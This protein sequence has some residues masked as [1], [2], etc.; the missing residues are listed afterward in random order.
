MKKS[1]LITGSLFVTWMLIIAF[2]I[3][4]CKKDDNPIK[5]P[6]GTIPDTTTTALA[7][8]NSAYDDYNLSLYQLYDSYGLIFSSNRGSSGGQFDLEQGAVSFIWDQT[9]GTFGFGS[10]ET[11]DIF[12]SALT[13]QANTSGNDFGPYTFFSTVDGYN[14][15][16]LSSENTSGDLDF[17]FLKYLPKIN[18]DLPVIT[19]P[20]AAT[21]LN[22]SSDDAYISFDTNRDTAYYSSN[23]SGNFN[24][25]LKQR[26]AE[27]SMVT[28]LGGSYSAG[29]PVDS[30]N[31]NDEDKCP[32]VLNKVMAFASDRAGGFGGFD[33]YYAIYKHGKW[34]TPVNFGPDINTA[35]N[36]YRPIIENP[37][38]Y[39]NTLL[40]FSSDR[41]GG[42][43]RYDIYFRGVTIES[44]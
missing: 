16:M 9:N 8:L 6:K 43:G 25:Y 35:Y 18:N 44:E 21:L 11:S 20:F 27:T 22:S 23:V 41:P 17:Y 4:S 7:D 12:L 19:G 13:N 2:S 42:K 5:F 34:S 38:N 1:S 36:E 39:T 33:L 15:L 31:S 28:W 26:P 24:I 37:D 40:M 29:T 3:T 32:F 10:G 14:Y 30:L